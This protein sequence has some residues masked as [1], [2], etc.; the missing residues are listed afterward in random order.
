MKFLKEIIH[1][2]KDSET[3]I[4]LDLDPEN[5]VAVI[6]TGK[7]NIEEIFATLSENVTFVAENLHPYEHL[8]SKYPS[9]NLVQGNMINTKLDDKSID[10]IVV[11]AGLIKLDWESVRNELKRISSSN[12]YCDVVIIDEGN[13]NL[14]TENFL[15]FLY[16]GSWYEVKEFGSRNDEIVKIYQ[17]PI[18]FNEEEL[19]VKEITEF[20][21]ACA[22]YCEIIENFEKYTVKEFLYNI[23]KTLVNYYLKGFNLPNCCRSGKIS[24]DKKEIRKQ[25]KFG[26]YL[27]MLSEY[28]K[29]VEPYFSN[30]NPYP[31]SDEIEEK[32]V[33]SQSLSN[34]LSEIYHDIKSN[35]LVFRNNSIPDQQ[36]AIW[37]FKFDWQGHTG[38]HWTFA[39]RAIHWKLQEIR[40][41]D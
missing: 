9:L 11:E 41:D 7:I 30:F 33:T 14:I 2:F 23:Q 26:Y 24:F 39:V 15:E 22:D 17:N 6:F 10:F 38:D 28:L 19:K 37:Q 25:S 4:G 3:G 20:I 31:D 40:Y 8:K 32:E 13:P 36:D 27:K 21:N 12:G 29:N 35:L 34:D 1:Y 16:A 18:G 5:K